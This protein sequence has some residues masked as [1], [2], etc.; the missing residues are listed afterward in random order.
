VGRF[1]RNNSNRR[2][3]DRQVTMHS[4]VCDACGREC[5]VPFRPSGDKP[6][7]CS[8]CFEQQGGGRDRDRGD[9]RDSRNSRDDRDFR[10]SGDRG[11]KGMYSA[12]CDD[13]G[14]KCLVPFKPSSDKPIYCSSCFEKRG[15]SHDGES[16]G[17]TKNNI[18]IEKLD[19]IIE[20]LEK[21]VL[22]LEVKAIPVEKKV[23]KEKAVKKEPA[24]KKASTKKKSTKKE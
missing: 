2:D 12:I 22:A 23:T 16:K 10:D 1:N 7:Y 3:S 14:S 17:S 4:A 11:G 20:K 21:I 9:R 8:S 5:K 24:K 6:I 13:C 18:Q 15:N 19:L